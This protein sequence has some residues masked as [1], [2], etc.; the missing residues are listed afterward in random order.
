[1]SDTAPT[2]KPDRHALEVIFL[3]HF[4][5]SHGVSILALARLI[6]VEYL[7]YLVLKRGAF[8]PDR[9]KNTVILDLMEEAKEIITQKITGFTS[10]SAYLEKNHA[11]VESNRDDCEKKYYEL[12]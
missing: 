1:M 2:L 3:K 9:F 5:A 8:V 6:A 7:D 10:I 11:E 12:F 4:Y